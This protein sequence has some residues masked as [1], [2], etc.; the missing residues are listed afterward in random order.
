MRTPAETTHL[1]TCPMCGHTYD[2][3]LHQACRTCPL[4][5]G[6]TLACCPACGYETV[7]PNRSTLV[8]FFRR[9]TRSGLTRDGR[10]PNSAGPPSSVDG[11]L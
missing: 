9:L 3:A 8:A 10:D 6:C 2:P 4:N 11:Q 1:I 5:R 7:D